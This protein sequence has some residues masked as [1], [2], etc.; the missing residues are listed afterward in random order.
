RPKRFLVLMSLSDANFADSQSAF[1]EGATDAGLLLGGGLVLWTTWVLGTTIGALAGSS[2]GSLERLGIDVVMAAFFAATM[3]GG[4][5]GR[6][7]I[8]TVAVAA[9]VATTTLG[10]LPAGWN[11][12]AAA[13]CGGTVGA[14]RRAE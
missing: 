9:L 11:I 3:V 10:L 5:D 1:K 6:A 7:S 12:I 8:L 4:L 14:L 2:F 13:L